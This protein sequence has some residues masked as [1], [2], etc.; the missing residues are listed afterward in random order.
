ME[1]AMMWAKVTGR[2][3]MWNDASD[4]PKSSTRGG[5]NRSQGKSDVSDEDV[6]PQN[7]ISSELVLFK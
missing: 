7:K 4:G 5:R 2:G 1:D 6:S 3:T